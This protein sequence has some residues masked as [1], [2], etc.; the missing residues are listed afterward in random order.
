MVVM[1]GSFSLNADFSVAAFADTAAMQWEASPSPSVWRK[2]LH[3][4]GSAEAGVVTSVVRY[5]PDS[6][7]AGHGHPGGEEILVLEGT[8]S[9]EHGDWPVGTYLLNP[10]GFS[11]APF[12]HEGCVLFVKLR[13]YSGP[14]AQLALRTQEL[15]W[16]SGSRP[17]VFRKTLYADAECGERMW[18]ERWA[19]GTYPREMLCDGGLELFVLSGE[20]Q[21]PHTG[22]VGAW[23]RFPPGSRPSFSSP[24][25]AEIYMKTGH[26]GPGVLV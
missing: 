24:S 13:Q 2:R 1:T 19:P 8:F 9:D 12:S 15:N 10:E 5:D 16:E 22:A 11:H 21:G 3:L 25:G 20:L 23:F 7:F 17:N 14:R 6:S 4:S 18:L 26:L